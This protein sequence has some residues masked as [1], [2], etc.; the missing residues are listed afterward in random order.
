L[1]AFTGFHLAY[2][3]LIEALTA[4]SG[5]GHGDE[6]PNVRST[7]IPNDRPISL[8]EAVLVARGPFSQS[9]VRRVSTPLG[10]TGTYR[11][12]LRQRNEINQHHP[13]TTVWVDR[14]SGQIRDVR[15]PSKFT[16]AQTFTVWLWPLHTGEAFGELGRLIWFLVGLMPLILYISG[17]YYWLQRKGLVRDRPVNLVENSQKVR[18]VSKQS[19]IYIWT[20]LRSL[21]LKLLELVRR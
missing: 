12:N 13:I 17:I 16:A 3:P 10:D 15:N 2:P 1:L 8:T 19:A 21:S 5:M 14:W 18:Q 7:A 9:E 6:G 4:S 11:I 20:L